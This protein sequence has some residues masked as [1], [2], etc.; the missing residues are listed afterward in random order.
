MLLDR[1][2]MPPLRSAAALTERLVLA[3]HAYQVNDHRRYA[4]RQGEAGS[5]GGGGGSGGDGGG[6]GGG[7]GGGSGGDGDGKV[8]LYNLNQLYKLEPST[9]GLWCGVLRAAPR[10]VLWLLEPPHGGE[11]L[12]REARAC[13]VAAARRLRFAPVVSD[14]GAHLRRLGHAHLGLDTPEYNCHTTGSDALWAGVPLV[15]VS[16]EQMAARVA[17]SLLRASGASTG[18]VRSLREYHALS[19]GLV[20]GAADGDAPGHSWSTLGAGARST[21]TS[22]SPPPPRRCRWPEAG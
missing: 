17:G 21:S 15:T 5:G 2:A 19:T 4:A 3:P 20:N 14:V 6:G 13:G 12:R 8:N 18:V 10:A 16:G 1:H 22:S 7:G 11:A 9:L